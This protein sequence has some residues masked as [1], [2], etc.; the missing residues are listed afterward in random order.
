M[1]RIAKITGASILLAGASMSGISEHQELPPTS[2]QAIAHTIQSKSTQTKRTPQKVYHRFE[3]IPEIAD[4]DAHFYDKDEYTYIINAEK[5]QQTG[6][7]ELKRVLAQEVTRA[8]TLSLIYRS[9]CGT[10]TPKENEDQIIHYE[11]DLKLINPSGKYK[12]P[13]Q[14]NDT[15]V[16]LY[17]KYL[18]INPQTRKYVLPLLKFSP[19]PALKQQLM[20]EQKEGQ[21][22]LDVALS[23]L[24]KKYF[25]ETGAT[26]SMEERS[27]LIQNNIFMS[28]K[29]D[30]TAW[31]K[32]ASPQLKK[33]IAKEEK[34]RNKTLSN[35]T[36]NYLCLT[37]MLPS[38]DFMQQT[39][40]DYNLTSFSLGRVGK[41]KQV[42]LALALS[43][44][45]K[46]KE[47]NLD[48]TRIPTYAIAAAISHIN[49]KGNG[50]A[51]LS[52]AKT[53]TL[54][55]QF[56]ISWERGTNALKEKVKTWV[57]G[58]GRANGVDELSKLNMIT[59]LLIKQ[60]TEI[61]LAGAKELAQKY[62]ELVAKKEEQLKKHQTVNL[63]DLY[64]QQQR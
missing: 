15:G 30:D 57:P 5:Y 45:L 23:H 18:A 14:M 46:N 10:Y 41:P 13:S 63:A 1:S 29:L 58:K 39:L 47:G 38:D 56:Q 61:E 11:V 33:F 25:D 49:W 43:M 62:Q 12:S 28:I 52:S 37:E 55:S 22:L 3:D 31:T 64:N 17:T 8:N 53:T 26:R 21:T 20:K 34:A 48:A 40:E 16:E 42:M 32:I 9:E 19:S 59:P 50:Q 35:T 51:A 24:E 44:N 36:K 60:Y 6:E 54:R 2:T 4:K 27:T 7:I